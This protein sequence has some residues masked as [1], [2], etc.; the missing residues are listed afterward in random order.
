MIYWFCNPSRKPLLYIENNR[1]IENLL[2]NKVNTETYCC[3]FV[4]HLCHESI[5][6]HL[7]AGFL[8]LSRLFSLKE[9][10]VDILA[11]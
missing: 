1:K 11:Y 2:I 5:R 7:H 4:T 8:F 9:K 6:V 3:P 10:K